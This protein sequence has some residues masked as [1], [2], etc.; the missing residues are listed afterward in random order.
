MLYSCTSHDTSEQRTPDQCT[1]CYTGWIASHT[2]ICAAG[3]MT[4]H[5]PKDETP[6]GHKTVPELLGIFYHS[7]NK[8]LDNTVE[9]HSRKQLCFKEW[10][11]CH[12]T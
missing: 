6:P 9:K 12:P 8:V 10:T 5:P 11:M 3:I 2:F 4:L 1:S 7:D